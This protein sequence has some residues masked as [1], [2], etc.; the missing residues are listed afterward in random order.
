MEIIKNFLY[1]NKND[2]LDPLSLI[3]KLYIY[4]YKPAGTKISILNNKMEIQEISLFQS[5]IRTFKGDT[6]NDLINMLFPLT[7]ACEIYLNEIEQQ[8]YKYIFEQAIKSFD[9]LNEMYQINEITHNIEQLKNIMISF[10]ENSKF[11]PK[12]IILNWDDKASE[13]KKSFYKQT[14]TVWNKDRL[15]ILFG[16]INEL[17][18]SQSDDLTEQ[19]ILSLSTFMNFMDLVVVKLINEL[20]LLR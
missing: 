9:K 4:S 10:L 1:P 19:L 3:I 8:K 13:L 2:I 14:N 17:S 7:F 20:H 6:K 16:H 12:T 18:I 5:T 11:N 15:D